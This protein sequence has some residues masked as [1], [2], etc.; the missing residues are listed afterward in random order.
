[1]QESYAGNSRIKKLTPT[2]IRTMKANM[3]KVPT[4]QKKSD[5]YHAS[6]ARKAE[7]LLEQHINHAESAPRAKK[8]PRPACQTLS[9]W[10]KIKRYL[11]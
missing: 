9:R 10:E 2:Q 6:E 1:M 4:I 7:A 11:F 3:R 8:I 5:A